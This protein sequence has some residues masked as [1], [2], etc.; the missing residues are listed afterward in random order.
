MDEGLL[1]QRM[2]P[3]MQHERTYADSAKAK[4]AGPAASSPSGRKVSDAR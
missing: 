4:L 3:E 1:L 2:S